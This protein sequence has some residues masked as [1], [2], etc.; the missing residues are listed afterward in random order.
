MH[1]ELSVED[2]PGGGL[3]MALSFPAAST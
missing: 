2:T 1:G 3:A